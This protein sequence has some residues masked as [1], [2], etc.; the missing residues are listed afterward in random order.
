MSED[1]RLLLSVAEAAEA[2]GVSDDLVYELTERGELPCLRLGRRKLVPRKAID[3]VIEHAL[4]G[5]E[6]EVL[7]SRLELSSVATSVIGTQLRG[8]APYE[9]AQR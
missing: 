5:F 8:V 3:L 7:V 9:R 1:G 2:L 4:S 6:P